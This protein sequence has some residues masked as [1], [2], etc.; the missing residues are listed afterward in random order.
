MVARTRNRKPTAAIGETS[1]VEI[2]EDDA[3]EETDE[4]YRQRLLEALRQEMGVV[5]EARVLVRQILLHYVG[6]D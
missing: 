1:E 3:T 2:E 6:I 4:E 5:M